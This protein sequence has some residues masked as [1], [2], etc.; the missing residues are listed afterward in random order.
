MFASKKIYVSLFKELSS[1][2]CSSK[3]SRKLFKWDVTV[4]FCGGFGERY[5]LLRNTLFFGYKISIVKFSNV[6]CWNLSNSGLILK[7]SPFLT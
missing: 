7:L 5:M 4:Q 6:F 2:K 1:F 3:V